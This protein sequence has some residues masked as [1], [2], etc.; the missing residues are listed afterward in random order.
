MG[1]YDGLIDEV[2]IYNRGLDVVALAIRL[3]DLLIELVNS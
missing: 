1:I 2:R 3:G